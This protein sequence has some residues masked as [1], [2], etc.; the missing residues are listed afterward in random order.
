MMFPT[1][2]TRKD[3]Q[4]MSVRATVVGSWTVHNKLVSSESSGGRREE[5]KRDEEEEKRGGSGG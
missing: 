5:G 1:N 4:Y 3:R 2:P